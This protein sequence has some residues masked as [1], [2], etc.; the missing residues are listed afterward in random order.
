MIEIGTSEVCMS[1]AGDDLTYYLFKGRKPKNNRILHITSTNFDEPEALAIAGAA[2]L[3]VTIHGQ[4]GTERFVDVGGLASEL[5]STAV[6]CLTAAGFCAS[7]QSNPKLQ[8]LDKRNIC[9]R[10]QS[11]MGLQIEISRG[12]RDVFLED[13]LQLLVFAKAIRF[14]FQ[15]HSLLGCNSTVPKAT[16][17]VFD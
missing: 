17:P 2:Q 15:K 13:E 3:V 6:S 11:R 5:C 4:S 12:L 14:A 9:N 10:G 8:G 7:T 1:I 16:P